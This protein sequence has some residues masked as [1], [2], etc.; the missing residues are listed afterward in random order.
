MSNE[1][2]AHTNLLAL[3]IPAT[4]V[5]V[6]AVVVVESCTCW[7]Q[8]VVAVAVGFMVCGVVVVGRGSGGFV[9]GLRLVQHSNHPCWHLKPQITA[10]QERTRLQS[11]VLLRQ[12]L[13]VKQE[14]RTDGYRWKY[15]NHPDY[16]RSLLKEKQQQQ[17]N[18]TS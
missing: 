14:C 7:L 16:Y 5:V 1:F 18:H 13:Q 8:T 2:H 3:E 9:P 12:A 6:A 10:T 15:L 4:V 11:Q 17:Q